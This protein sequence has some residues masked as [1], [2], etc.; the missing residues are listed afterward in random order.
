MIRDF[1]IRTYLQR[2][3]IMGFSTL[4][5][6]KEDLASSA[7]HVVFV[8][9]PARSGRHILLYNRQKFYQNFNIKSVCKIFWSALGAEIFSVL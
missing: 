9:F 3:L 7:K 4:S 6:P 2:Q 5:L 8:K 1:F